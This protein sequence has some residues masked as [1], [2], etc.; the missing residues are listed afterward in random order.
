MQK[1]D[2]S[3]SVLEL[4]IEEVVTEELFLAGLGGVV[5]GQ[6]LGRRC[7][8][9]R[10][11]HWSLVSWGIGARNVIIL[12]SGARAPGFGATL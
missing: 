5:L 10:C 8:P 7:G 9:E 6:A 2:I 4:E 11:G 3:W 12:K 1:L